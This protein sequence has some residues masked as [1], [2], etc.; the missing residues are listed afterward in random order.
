MREYKGLHPGCEACREWTS[1]DAHHIVS[2]GSGGPTE[3]WNLLALCRVCHTIFHDVGWKK[4][5]DR[6]P[7][8]AG[9][10]T[11]ARI[12]MGRKTN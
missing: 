2:E 7:H 11:A 12:I 1:D 4:A 5:I 6:F 10:V 9:K 8:L 3:V